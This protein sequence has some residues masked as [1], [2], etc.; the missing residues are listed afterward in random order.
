V[1]EIYPQRSQRAHGK[2]DAD[3]MYGADGFHHQKQDQKSQPDDCNQIHIHT[4]F[5][6]RSLAVWL[7]QYHSIKPEANQFAQHTNKWIPATVYTL[8]T[9]KFRKTG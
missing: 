8:F 1:E 9:K 7:Y 5:R 3:Q 6:E 2:P 4:S